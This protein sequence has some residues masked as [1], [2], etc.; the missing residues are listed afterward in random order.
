MYITSSASINP[1]ITSVVTAP[2]TMD[3]RAYWAVESACVGSD[4]IGIAQPVT[5][6]MAPLTV[7]PTCDNIPCRNPSFC[8]ACRDPDARKARGESP[9]HIDPSRWRGLP[10]NIREGAPQTTVEALML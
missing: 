10:D 2:S 8:E 1:D 9:R 3:W 7:C 5:A 4:W 6:I